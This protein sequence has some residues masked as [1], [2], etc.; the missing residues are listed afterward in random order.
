MARLVPGADLVHQG[1]E[2][3]RLGVET[4]AALLVSIGAPRLRRLGFDVASP[5]TQPEH[6][7]YCLLAR[8][9][10][11]HAAHSRYNALVRRLVSFERLGMRALAD[12]VCIQRF[13][14]ELGAAASEDACVYF[15][16]GAT[17]VLLGWRDSTIAID[18]RAVPEHDS[19]LRAIPRLKEA[20]DVNVEL[21]SPDHFIPVQPG[22]EDRSPFIAREGP[23]SFHH[24]DLYAQALSKIERGHSQDVEDVREMFARGLIERGRLTAYFDAIA[25]FIYRYPALDADAFRGAVEDAVRDPGA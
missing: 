17:A 3:L 10:R 22:W 20:L 23:V 7:L 14:R 6:R 1:L 8:S 9:A 12:G 16:G 18:M 11:T 13:M 21:A 15:T 2:D 4:E 5:F 25:P 24:F 19:L